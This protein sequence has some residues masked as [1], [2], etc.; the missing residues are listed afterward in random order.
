MACI[1]LTRG[2]NLSCRGGKSGFKAVGF[3]VWEEGL[4]TGT[5]GEVATLPGG[6]TEVYRYQL[7]N[8]GNTYTEEIAS[9]A[10][11]RTVVYNGTL[12]IILHKLDLETRN[13]IKMLA[14]GELIIFIET[15]NGDIFVIGADQG[16][17]L[18]GGTIAETGGA[19]QDFQ[20]SKLTFTTSDKE[21]Y[22]RLSTSAKTAYAGIVI[23]G[24]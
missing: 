18:T 12:S 3:A 20:G 5:N 2:R 22:L 1:T 21:P 6:L 9:D 16:A 19:P 4:I 17:E 15:Y 24:V 23:G 7:K 13:E 10:E 8:T 11:S 14:M